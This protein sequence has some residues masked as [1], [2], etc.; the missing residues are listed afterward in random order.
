MDYFEIFMRAIG[1]LVISILVFLAYLFGRYFFE[2]YKIKWKAII[3]ILLVVMG[4]VYFSLEGF[5]YYN[6]TGLVLF[7]TLFFP[8]LLGALG[9][10]KTRLPW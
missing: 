3:F 6:E 7:F 1:N 5:E 4:F 9:I 10:F 2:K 8:G